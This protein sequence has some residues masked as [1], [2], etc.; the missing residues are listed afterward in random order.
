MQYQLGRA[1]LAC[2]RAL[3]LFPKPGLFSLLST[4]FNPFAFFLGSFL[5]FLP[6][7]FVASNMLTSF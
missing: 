2:L 6:L 4:R 3:L 5:E 1:H 7:V